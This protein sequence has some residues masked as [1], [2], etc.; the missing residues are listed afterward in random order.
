[1]LLVVE[2]PRLAVINNAAANNRLRKY[3][4][5]SVYWQLPY[6][7][8]TIDFDDSSTSHFL[9]SSLSLRIFRTNQTQIEFWWNFTSAALFALIS[10]G[11]PSL[12][13][14]ICLCKQFPEGGDDCNAL[15]IYANSVNRFAWWDQRR[16]FYLWFIADILWGK[17]IWRFSREAFT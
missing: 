5:D 15:I 6:K 7:H 17:F 16:V 11:N 9:F 10:S 8:D 4:R 1:M 3:L 13:D 12:I 14:V 2:V